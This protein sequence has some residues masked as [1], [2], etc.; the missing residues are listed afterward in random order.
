MAKARNR[1]EPLRTKLLRPNCQDIA[2]M[3]CSVDAV[4]GDI[5]YSGF[6]V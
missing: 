2:V 1:L 5:L 6:P 3:N 4:Q